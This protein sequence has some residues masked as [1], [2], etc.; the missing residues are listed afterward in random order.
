MQMPL[1][2]TSSCSVVLLDLHSSNIFNN[3]CIRN[4]VNLHILCCCWSANVI[5][6]WERDPSSVT[7]PV[8]P[9][10]FFPAKS[11]LGKI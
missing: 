3:T 8:V 2:N 10:I 9:C 4:G 7:L 1:G 11:F 5:T 6:S